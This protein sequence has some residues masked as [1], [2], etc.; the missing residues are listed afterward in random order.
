MFIYREDLLTVTSVGINLNH[1]LSVFVS[2]NGDIFIDRGYSNGQVSKILFN[3]SN[4]VPVVNISGSCYGLFL[5]LN[6][7]LYCSLKDLHQVVKLLLDSSTTIPTVAAGNGSSGSDSNMLNSPQGIYVDKDFNLY[8]ADCGNDR[9]QFFQPGQIT[10]TT[11]VGNGSSINMTLR[12][13]T[14]ITLDGT[15]YLFVVDSQNHRIIGSSSAGYRCIAGCAGVAGS[16]PTQLSFPQSMA[17]DSFGNIYVAD[18]NNSRIQKFFKQQTNCS[19][20]IS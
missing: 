16:A 3:S 6:N 19:K 11:I 5:A 17:F 12:C 13:P 14:S 4:T 2:L 8:V 20:L 7:Y 18:R 1:S 10:G 9:V 15:G